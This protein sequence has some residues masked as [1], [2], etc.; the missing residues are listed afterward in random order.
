MS[1]SDFDVLLS[2]ITTSLDEVS[3]CF[4][5]TVFVEKFT[6]SSPK[7]VTPF[8]V[9]SLLLSTLILKVRSLSA[10]AVRRTLNFRSSLGTSNILVPTICVK[11]I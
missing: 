8:F 7:E 3:P 9:A 10:V 4:I 11:L 5:V 2:V 1:S 6:A